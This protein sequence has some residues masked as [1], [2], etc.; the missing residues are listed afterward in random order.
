MALFDLAHFDAMFSKTIVLI[1]FLFL[2]KNCLKCFLSR[3]WAFFDLLC[4]YLFLAGSRFNTLGLYRDHVV[5]QWPLF[6]SQLLAK[7]H[8]SAFV[9]NRQALIVAFS[10]FKCFQVGSQSQNEDSHSKA[11]NHAI[12][13]EPALLT[14]QA[15]P[16]RWTF[17]R[18]NQT[19]QLLTN[20]SKSNSNWQM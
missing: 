14:R 5:I 18:Q 7:A 2:M 1:K 6:V 11:I 3:S 12:V 9:H 15:N 10:I 19:R 4:S 16:R 8:A 20:L 17:W 13:T